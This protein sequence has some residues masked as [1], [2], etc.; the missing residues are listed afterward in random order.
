M[1]RVLV[2]GRNTKGWVRLDDSTV[3]HKPV[4]VQGTGPATMPQP[5]A[6]PELNA[7]VFHQSTTPSQQG[8]PPNL[9]RLLCHTRMPHHTIA[10]F[11]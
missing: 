2:Y 6:T 3:R 8:I 4:W 11:R 7:R 10:L 1:G 5:L 9:T